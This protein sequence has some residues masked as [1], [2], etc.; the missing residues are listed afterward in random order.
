MLMP[1]IGSAGQ[2]RDYCAG[3]GFGGEGLTPLLA[4]V[5]ADLGALVTPAARAV[6]RRRSSVPII[7]VSATCSARS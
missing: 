5:F 3:C 2:C 1:V 6:G 7:D 4:L